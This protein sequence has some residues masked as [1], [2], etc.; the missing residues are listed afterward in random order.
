MRRFWDRR[1][2]EDAFYFVDNRLRYGDPDV[3]EFWTGGVE[4]MEFLARHLGL[5][6]EPADT[7]LD[8]GCGVGRI[9]R[10]LSDSAQRVLALDVSPEML[11]RA[12]ELNPRAANV[13]WLLGDGTSLKGVEDD[14]V[15]ACVSQVVLQHIPDPAITLGYVREIGRVLRAGGWA[16]IQVS[17]DPSVHQ[18]RS[19]LGL[20]LRAALGR[21]PGGQSHAAWLGSSV[22]LDELRTAAAEGGLQV[23]RIQG[24]GTLFCQVVLRKA[25]G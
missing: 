9:T 4:V 18:P 11:E 22:D 12:R 15:D 23:E 19:S 5:R 21:A 3:D 14:A 24:E 1:A 20:R 8:I 16:A 13:E 10:V 17:N 6:V 2:R 25:P 7:A